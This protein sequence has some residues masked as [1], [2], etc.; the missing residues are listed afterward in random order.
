MFSEQ[1]PLCVCVFDLWTPTSEPCTY[2][3][4]PILLISKHPLYGPKEIQMQIFII[5]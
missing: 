1:I 2:Q 3:E 4:D 5:K